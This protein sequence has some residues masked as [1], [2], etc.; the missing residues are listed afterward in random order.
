MTSLRLLPA[1]AATQFL[2]RAATRYQD[3]AGEWAG[4]LRVRCRPG[5][6]HRR[7]RRHRRRGRAGLR[8]LDPLAGGPR[9][10]GRRLPRRRPGGGRPQGAGRGD[11]RAGSS[12]RAARRTRRE[13]APTSRRAC[14]FVLERAGL[15]CV[16]LLDEVSAANRVAGDQR[17]RPR[18]RRRRLHRRGHHPQ[19]RAGP[20]RRPARR[21]AP[22]RP[23]PGR[24][25]ADPPGRG[26]EPQAGTGRPLP[27]RPAPGPRAGG[28]QHRAPLRAATA[29][30]PSTWSAAP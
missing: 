17:R 10:R 29:T 5:H 30:S 4:P 9:R 6:G 15:D 26:R 1:P 27:P 24:S 14:Q 19:R 3:P 13:W 16:S 21:R 11:P 25:P 7:L 22:P 12:P 2:E 28:Q 23:H 18:R 20:G 8:R